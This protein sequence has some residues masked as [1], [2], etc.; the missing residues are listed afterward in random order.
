[1]L[2]A[3]GLDAGS[4]DIQIEA[5]HELAFVAVL[6]RLEHAVRKYA[7]VQDEQL[8]VELSSQARPAALLRCGTS[9]NRPAMLARPRGSPSST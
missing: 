7:V 5:G 1:M 6:H 9:V 8:L 2:A 4:V 3:S